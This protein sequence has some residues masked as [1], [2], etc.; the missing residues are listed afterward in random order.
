MNAQIIS[1]FLETYGTLV[2]E[3]DPISYTELMMDDHK[4]IEIW[5]EQYYIPENGYLEEDEEV[6]DYLIEHYL[7]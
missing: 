7:Y 6:Y 3:D 4:C 1:D 2:R 5:D